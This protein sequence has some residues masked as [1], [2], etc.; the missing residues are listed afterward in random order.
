MEEKKVLERKEDWKTGGPKK[1]R[2][3]GITTVVSVSQDGRTVKGRVGGC[4]EKI[5]LFKGVVS[6]STGWAGVVPGERRDEVSEDRLV[7]PCP[8]GWGGGGSE[9]FR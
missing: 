6:A 4:E 3:R 2:K 9:N 8:R 5:F 7:D 1:K